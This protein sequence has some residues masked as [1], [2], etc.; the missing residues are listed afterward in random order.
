METM[1]YQ[2]L[3]SDF[4]KSFSGRPMIKNGRKMRGERALN[5]KSKI[6]DVEIN[7]GTTKNLI[8]FQ[9]RRYFRTTVNVFHLSMLSL[10]LSSFLPKKAIKVKSKTIWDKLHITSKIYSILN[11]AMLKF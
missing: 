2:I 7:C 6:I 10:Y 1:K 4:L 5:P 11:I 9:N 8:F 3:I